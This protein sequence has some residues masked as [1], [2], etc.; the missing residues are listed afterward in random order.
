MRL[1]YPGLKEVAC[2]ND[3]EEDVDDLEGVDHRN[4]EEAAVC[5]YLWKAV[6]V[7]GGRRRHI[8]HRHEVSPGQLALLMTNDK[9]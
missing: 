1:P 9:D 7:G 4:H 5:C 2:D 6:D 3:D 8:G